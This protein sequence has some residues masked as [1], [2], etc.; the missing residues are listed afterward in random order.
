MIWKCSDCG[1]FFSVV[2]EVDVSLCPKCGSNAI[3]RQ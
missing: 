2:E 3:I 1:D